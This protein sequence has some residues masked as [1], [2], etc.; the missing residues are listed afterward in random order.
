MREWLICGN[1]K[2]GREFL[3][4]CFKNLNWFGNSYSS[5]KIKQQHPFCLVSLPLS[6]VLN[7]VADRSG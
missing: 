6:S 2:Y 1:H 7:L 3:N 5:K 4:F